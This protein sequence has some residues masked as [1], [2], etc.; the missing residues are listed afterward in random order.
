MDGAPS[1]AV[2]LL[3]VTAKLLAVFTGVFAVLSFGAALVARALDEGSRHALL[4]RVIA[5]RNPRAR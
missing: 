1:S 3:A 5:D 2:A 4:L